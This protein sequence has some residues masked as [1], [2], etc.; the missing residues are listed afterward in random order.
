[1][2]VYAIPDMRHVLM[3]I[4]VARC[5]RTFTSHMCMIRYVCVCVHVGVFVRVSA[6]VYACVFAR[7]YV[8][9]RVCRYASMSVYMGKYAMY[10]ASINL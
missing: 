2:Q 5:R 10:L 8:V 1:M 7:V 4:C 3:R 9:L 6:C